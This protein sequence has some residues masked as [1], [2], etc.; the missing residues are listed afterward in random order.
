MARLDPSNYNGFSLSTD[1]II[2]QQLQW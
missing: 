1:A 2:A